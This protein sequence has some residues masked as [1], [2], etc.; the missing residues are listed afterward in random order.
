VGAFPSATAPDPGTRVREAV[1]ALNV[2]PADSHAEAL[3]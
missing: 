2:R 1:S 3:A